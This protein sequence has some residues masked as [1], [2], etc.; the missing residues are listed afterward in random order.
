MR[1][2]LPTSPHRCFLGLQVP[3]RIVLSQE[4]EHQ[5]GFRS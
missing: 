4:E 2:E 1:P 5:P 3:K